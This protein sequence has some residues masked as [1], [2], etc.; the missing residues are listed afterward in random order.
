[1]R[2]LADAERV[3]VARQRS[4]GV[5]HVLLGAAV[6]HDLFLGLEVVHLAVG[7]DVDAVAAE[8]D[9]RHL[10]RDARAE[11]AVEEQEAQR[12]A[13]EDLRRALALVAARELEDVLEL[14]AREVAGGEQVALGQDTFRSLKEAGHD[15]TPAMSGTSDD[16][17]RFMARCLELARAAAARDEVPVGAVVVRDGE[18]V[19]EGSN[20]CVELGDPTAHAEMEA[21]RSAFA[22]SGEARLVGATLY[23]TLEPCFMCAGAA[24]HS[25]VARIVFG[26]RDPK[27]G[28]CGSLA[29]LPGDPRLNHRCPVDEGVAAEAIAAELRA[30][31]R[32]LRGSAPG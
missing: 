29:N 26:T 12:L 17:Q 32:R 16:D 11:T 30:F 14:R 24:L 2:E 19:G 9:G 13:R 4:R 27:F 21:L 7:E 18:I 15:R 20:R 3:D 23:C 1:M 10:E 8:L 6:H 28:A 25:R 22:R 31:F 5:L